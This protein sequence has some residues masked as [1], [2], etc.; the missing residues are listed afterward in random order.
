MCVRVKVATANEIK[1]GSLKYQSRVH[2]LDATRP[3]AFKETRAFVPFIYSC[4]RVCILRG[5]GGA[6]RRIAVA[7]AFDSLQMS[8]GAIIA[9]ASSN[10]N[11]HLQKLCALFFPLL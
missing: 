2:T 10:R 1:K 6:D 11:R 5:K 8:A 4:A 9:T 3:Y 7:V